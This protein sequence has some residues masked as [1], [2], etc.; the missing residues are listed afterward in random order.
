[1]DLRPDSVMVRFLLSLLTADLMSW[2]TVLGRSTEKLRSIGCRFVVVLVILAALPSTLSAQGGN[3]GR[4]GTLGGV[5]PQGQYPSQQYYIA[6]SAYRAGDLEAAIDL[7]DQVPTRRDINGRWIDSIPVLA[8]EAE[9]YYQLG[10][11]PAVRERVDEV[12]RIAIRNRGW[13]NRV[14]WASAL[15]PVQVAPVNGL[16]PEATAVK[17]L[18]VTDKIQIGSG[19]V[20]NAQRIQQGGAIEELTVRTMDVVEIMRGLAIASYRRRILL[21]PLAAQDAL[22][23]QLLDA[24]KFPPGVRIPI[25]DSLIGSL[26]AVERFSY[27]DD[28]QAMADAGRYSTLNGAVHPLT[29]LAMLAQASAIAGTVKPETA[30]PIAINIANCAAALGQ[31]E[32]AGEAMQLAAGCA[33]TPEQSELVR[34]AASTAGTGLYRKSRLASL[35]CLV[36]AS[37]GAVS[38]GNAEAASTTLS[39]AK[40][41]SAQRSVT[42]PRIDAYGAYVAAR[43][44]AAAGESVG[45]TSP[46]GVD[47][48]IG[49]MTAFSLQRRDRKRPVISMPRIYQLSLIRQAAGN[50]LGG[51]TSEKLLR[52]FSG[53]PPSGVWRR[54]AVDAL[55]AVLLDQTDALSARVQLAAAQKYG[56]ELLKKS[57]DLY[58]ARFYQQL[59][60]GGR[61]AQVRVIARSEDAML[62]PKALEFRKLAGRPMTQLRQAAMAMKQPN[63][64]ESQKLEAAACLI[65]LGRY[66]I[67]RSFPPQLDEKLPLA[68]LPPRTGLLT[69]INVGNKSYATLSAEGKSSMWAI[70]GASRVPDEIGR[71][72]RGIGV[73]KPRGNRLPE[74]E[75]WRADA[76]ALRR[77]LLPDDATITAERFDELII[78]P[79]GPLWYLPFELLPIGGEQSPLI[80]D[81]MRVR[82]AATPGLALHPAGPPPVSRSIG[83]VADYFFAPGEVEINEAIVESIAAVASDPVRMPSKVSTTTGLLGNTIGHLVVAAPRVPNLQSPLSMHVAPYDQANPAG[84][85]SGWM[86][87]PA[88]VP[89]TVVMPGFRTPVDVG[90]KGSGNEVF[91]TLCGLN[92]AGVRSVL[93]SRWAVGGESTATALREFV[94]ELPFSGMQA[95]WHRARMVLRRTELDPSREPLLTQ[96]DHKN[97]GVTGNEPLFWAGYL[98]STP[99]SQ[100]DPK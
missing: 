69:F 66:Q 84:T 86:R 3:V 40:T 21:G 74:D 35:H 47:K 71:L 79:D 65:A 85:I 97:E 46:S 99:P 8:M 36:A 26:R 24:T 6:L 16:W 44:A 68:K 28:A 63:V 56:E 23:S 15:Q 45:I 1:M 90:K 12:F 37:D 50:T 95:S 87:F 2:M 70:G 67:P 51:K 53:D 81:S 75:S 80:A 49:L 61:I 29:P 33:K 78:V 100:P 83:L 9:C 18:P 62:T 20:L 42:Q 13:L 55:S 39:Q 27:H 94:Q 34:K 58:A 30:I 11:M 96:A 77:H 25:A 41:L 76:V 91:M 48:A 57:D 31:P 60:L 7:F 92:A 10:H 17:R 43:L 14:D 82:Y 32:W 98:I 88:E 19:S 73:G 54:D 4:F 93:L 72:L 5:E 59:P 64:L 38:A 22:A 52:A 89:R